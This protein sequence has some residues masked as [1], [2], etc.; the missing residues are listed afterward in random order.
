MDPDKIPP[1]LLDKIANRMIEQVLDS[2]AAIAEVDRRLLAG[3]S[4][5]VE[6]SARP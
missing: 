3:E 4:V 6:P 1:E 2:T 5:T